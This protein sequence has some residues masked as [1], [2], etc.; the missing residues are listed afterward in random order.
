VGARIVEGVANERGP[1]ALALKRRGHDRVGDRDHVA[2][3]LVDRDRPVAVL[4]DLVPVRGAGGVC[5][6]VSSLVMWC[7]VVA[8]VNDGAGGDG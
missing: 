6:E 3:P 1:D 5:G 4:Q 8:V 2:R 7:A